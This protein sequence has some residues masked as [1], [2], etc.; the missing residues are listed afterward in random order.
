MRDTSELTVHEIYDK[1]WRVGHVDPLGDKPTP[2]DRFLGVVREMG[3]R[4]R[5]E[6]NGA[7]ESGPYAG[8]QV[9]AADTND[10]RLYF[11]IPPEAIPLLR[12][13]LTEEDYRELMDGLRGLRPEDLIV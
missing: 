9:I 2:L 7:L 5:A 11:M 12:D 13:Y 1:A 4:L 3:V 10:G 6:P 8:G